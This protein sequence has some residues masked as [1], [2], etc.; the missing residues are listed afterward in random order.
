MLVAAIEHGS[1]VVFGQVAWGAAGGEIKGARRL[2]REIDIESRAVTLDALHA[3]RKTASLIVGRGGYHVM[4]VGQAKQ[5]T[6]LDDIGSLTPGIPVLGFRVRTG[7]GVHD[8][9]E[10]SRRTSAATSRVGTHAAILIVRSGG[11][12]PYMPRAHRHFAARSG[13]AMHR[14]TQRLFP[15]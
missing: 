4:T 11:R 14:V 8:A 3:Q 13:D 15:D 7:L 12:S 9:R 5:Q 2:L 1:G 10:G 6:L